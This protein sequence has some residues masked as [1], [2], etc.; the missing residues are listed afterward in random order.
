MALTA[1]FGVDLH[2]YDRILVAFS[3]GKD[4]IACVLALL[5]AGVDPTRIELHHHDVDG[6]GR[7]FMDWECTPAYARAF[8][9]ALGLPIYFSQ[10]DGGFWGEMHRNN[11]ATASVTFDTIDGGR[12]TVGGQ[13]NRLNT[14]LRFPQVTAD[15]KTRWCSPY[16]KIGVM[17]AILCNDPRFETGATLIVTGER[18]QESA[19]RANYAVFEPHRAD[20]RTG[21]RR[22][23]HIDHLRPV[24]AWDEADVWR[25]IERHGINP[26]VAYQLGWG[27]LSCMACIFGSAAQW[28][29]IRAVFPERFER[30][31]EREQAFG[32]TIK[33]G[34]TIRDLADLGTPYAAALDRPD[35]CRQAASK[36]WT[37]PILLSRREWRLPAGAFG[38]CAGPN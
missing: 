13:S 28:A 12:R 38:E 1:T 9:S 32:C 36:T 3:G 15:L 17:D 16:L 10:R 2:A 29:T 25:I 20:L 11:Q 19:S 5:E 21:Q 4:S 7:A 23:R 18:A 6:G 26:H 37:Q 24:H 14:R 34:V 22:Q 8:A 31:A 27:R 35:L 33:R 30:V